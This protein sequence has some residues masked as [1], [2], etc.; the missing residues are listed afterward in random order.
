MCSQPIDLRHLKGSEVKGA[1]E[2]G[3][4]PLIGIRVRVSRL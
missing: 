2:E 4:G 1:D 3:V